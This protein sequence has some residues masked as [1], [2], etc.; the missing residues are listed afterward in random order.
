MQIMREHHRDGGW[1]LWEVWQKRIWGQ[2]SSL[3]RVRRAR[4]SGCAGDFSTRRL[5][6]ELVGWAVA[7]APFDACQACLKA[8]HAAASSDG[9]GTRFTRLRS[10]GFFVQDGQT[11]RS[12][13]PLSGE[14][15]LRQRD[16]LSGRV[17]GE[18]SVD[19]FFDL[20]RIALEDFD[21]HLA[22]RRCFVQAM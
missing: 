13:P 7:F 4:A 21:S 2:P 6:L 18:P 10:G 19:D 22:A 8:V 3:G 12:V 16:D 11:N 14:G 1:Y 9:Q 5:P 20:G 15:G 17:A